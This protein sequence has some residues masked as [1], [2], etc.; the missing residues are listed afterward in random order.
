MMTVLSP[1]WATLARRHTCQTMCLG[2]A[3]S[4]VF[5][6]RLA[7]APRWI[8]SFTPGGERVRFFYN[9]K[10][11]ARVNLVVTHIGRNIASARK[12]NELLMRSKHLFHISSRHVFS[13]AG[14]AGNECTDSA[15]SLGMRGLVSVSNV[16]S[17]WL[18]RWFCGQHFFEILTSSRMRSCKR[19]G[20]KSV[21]QVVVDRRSSTPRDGPVPCSSYGYVCWSW[22]SRRGWGPAPSV[23]FHPPL[24]VRV[25]AT[26]PVS[27]PLGIQSPSTSDIGGASLVFAQLIAHF[28]S[29]SKTHILALASTRKVGLTAG[30]LSCPLLFPTCTLPASCLQSSQRSRLVASTRKLRYRSSRGTQ[31]LLVALIYALQL[32][33]LTDLGTSIASKR[34]HAS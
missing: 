22:R 5:R 21:S 1:A 11:A 6:A 26:P 8:F 13:H 23:S 31:D 29:A 34:R 18:E 3:P 19:I 25:P 14:E 12:C 30:V 27:L 32:T 10:R 33:T 7:E 9:S 17:F 2:F 20:K 24:D 16:P 4:F 15:A 28:G